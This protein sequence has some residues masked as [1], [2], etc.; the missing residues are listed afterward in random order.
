MQLTEKRQA[1]RGLPL[2]QDDDEREGSRRLHPAVKRL[3]ILWDLPLAD[4][5]FADEQNEG[6]RL[7]ELLDELLSPRAAGAQ[8][9]G[10]KEDTGRRVLALDRGLDPLR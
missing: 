3:V 1:R 2:K 10:R 4:A 9:R 7:G 8:I 6:V 5:G